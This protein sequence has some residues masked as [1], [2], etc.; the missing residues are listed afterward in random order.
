MYQPAT[1]TAW[2][3]GP[4]SHRW[5][6]SRGEPALSR[7]DGVPEAS[8][9]APAAKALSIQSRADIEV[10]DKSCRLP[11]RAATIRQVRILRR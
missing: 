9:S 3:W 4:T 8:D 11:C 1:P 5:R 2:G 7:A 10:H 6:L